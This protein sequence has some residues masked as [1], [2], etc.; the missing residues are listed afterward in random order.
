MGS[1]KID[2]SGSRDWKHITLGPHPRPSQEFEHRFSSQPMFN[3]SSYP[4]LPSLSL[5]ISLIRAI[6]PSPSLF[7]PFRVCFASRQRSNSTPLHVTRTPLNLFPRLP[8]HRSTSL[9][10]CLLPKHLLPHSLSR[11]NSSFLMTE[12]FVLAESEI[13]TWWSL[14]ASSARPFASSRRPCGWRA[15][16]GVQ[17]WTP[18]A[19]SGRS[20]TA[21]SALKTI[22]SKH[23][24]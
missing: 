16:Y 11:S 20:R 10:I 24:S 22:I 2:A 12:P 18:R 14:A 5:I 6:S 4:C 9:Q 3:S 15:R 1:L 7:K 8:G 21:P 19:S 23:S 13:S 17:C